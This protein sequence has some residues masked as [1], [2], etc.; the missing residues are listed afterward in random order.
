MLSTLVLTTLLFGILGWYAYSYVYKTNTGGLAINPTQ[1]PV[2][3]EV[4]CTQDSDCVI[5]IQ[6]TSC[7]SC[8]KAVSRNTIG[9]KDWEVYEFGKDYSSRQ[10]NSCEGTVTCKQ[11]E[12]PQKP[13]C[14]GGRCKF[15]SNTNGDIDTPK[16]SVAVF[17]KL[18]QPDY[19]HDNKVFEPVKYTLVNN[20]SKSV[21]FLSG[22]V[23]SLPKVYEVRSGLKTKLEVSAISCKA[24][25]RISQI[26][27]G[28]S[29]E[30]GWNQHNLGKFVTDGLYQLAIEY[31]FEKSGDYNIGTK[32]EAT[33]DVFSVR[34][35]AWDINKQKQ[36]CELYGN[37]FHSNDFF[38]S[39]RY[40]LERLNQ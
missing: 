13:I 35:V 16:Q 10:S 5:G 39:K 7:C 31:S 27:S 20:S 30:L 40:C 34:Q 6:A 11:C 18:G 36:V 38:Y 4:A 28:K 24:L 9:N 14:S 29:V 21:Y 1:P 26:D 37:K 19:E 33:S 2:S 17:L 12:L 23:T 3:N 32:L 15:S 25:P 8:P 22:C